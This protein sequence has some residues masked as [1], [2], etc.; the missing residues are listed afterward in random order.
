MIRSVGLA[1][2]SLD[3]VDGVFS[4]GEVISELNGHNPH[5]E[6]GAGRAGQ[7]IQLVSRRIRRGTF[8]SVPSVA[9]AW[10]VSHTT[11]VDRLAPR[12]LRIVYCI[13]D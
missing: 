10:P 9:S 2:R 7:V 3:T 1:A 5:D 4:V 12:F 13:A 11:A 8:A 6:V